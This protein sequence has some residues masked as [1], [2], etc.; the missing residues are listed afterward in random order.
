[1]RN[2]KTNCLLML[3]P[4][5]V[6][7]G[8]GDGFMS[9]SGCLFGFGPDC[10]AVGP[11]PPGPAAEP[12]ALVEINLATGRQVILSS[13][14]VG[15]GPSFRQL[16][17]VYLDP[18]RDRV[19]IWDGQYGDRLLAVDLTSGNR[20][21]LVDFGSTPWLW[22]HL[23]W[24]P[25]HQIAYIVSD[26]GAEG[27]GDELIALDV[28]DSSSS[29]IASVREL[30]WNAY[31]LGSG[32]SGSGEWGF[33]LKLDDCVEGGE[34]DQ[35]GRDRCASVWRVHLASGAVSLASGAGVGRGPDLDIGWR[36]SSYTLTV[37]P[38]GNQAWVTSSG[39]SF[40]GTLYGV[41]LGSGERS[42]V[43][44]LGGAFSGRAIAPDLGNDRILAIE[45]RG[46]TSNHL[47]SID[48]TNGVPTTLF[49]VHMYSPAHMALDPPANRLLLV[50]QGTF[51]LGG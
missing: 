25:V 48:L 30:G 32:I 1:M 37:H 33:V 36:S 34:E 12:A 45:S 27:P 9:M 26:D 39:E 10:P 18:Q 19:L 29:V 24:D 43:A 31:S 4:L 7:C 47:V 42:K 22:H 21:I 40:S 20:E 14:S 8:D 3:V 38:S 50:S 49:E 41:D 6:G 44:E 46:S 11:P 51:G 23:D 17:G 28:Q 13:D 15:S 16:R 35:L 5:L 2:L